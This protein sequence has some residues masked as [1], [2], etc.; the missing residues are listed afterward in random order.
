M[1][2]LIASSNTE[3]AQNRKDAV[4]IDTAQRAGKPIMLSKAELLS[5]LENADANIY[6]QIDADLKAANILAGKNIM[7][8]VGAC[9]ALAGETKEVTPTNEDQVVT[10]SEGKNGITSITV[11]AVPIYVGYTP[12]GAISVVTDGVTFN[13]NTNTFAVPASL[14]E[15]TFTEGEHNMKAEIS[16][17]G[18]WVIGAAPM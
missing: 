11:K 4:I 12:Y 15:F 9:V 5:A 8:V 17:G 1:K 10:P 18:C 6:E 14:D 13:S 2:K 3:F 16:G 7:G